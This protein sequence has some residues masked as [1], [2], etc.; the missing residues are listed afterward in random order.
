MYKVF[1][2]DSPLFLTD[3][4]KSSPTFKIKNFEAINILEVIDDFFQGDI[5]GLN[6]YCNNL[7]ECWNVFQSKFKI[8]KAAGG[9]VMNTANEVLFIYRFNKWDLPKGK[10]EKD[11][12]IKECAIREVEEECGISNL[13]INK[14]LDTTYHIFKMKG[15]TILKVTYWFSMTTNYSAKLTPQ[16]EEGIVAVVFKNKKEANEALK[17]SYANI[18]LLF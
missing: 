13:V 6:L 7:E 3:K 16:L 9:K 15:E 1:V 18:K 5:D 10:L 4:K 8:Q 14:P 12:S 11:E 2:N 17:N